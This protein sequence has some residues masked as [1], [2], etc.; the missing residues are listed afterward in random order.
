[1]ER[2]FT[3]Q[4]FNRPITLRDQLEKIHDDEEAFTPLTDNV[5]TALEITTEGV[6]HTI[7]TP[8]GQVFAE[9]DS[10]EAAQFIELAPRIQQLMFSHIR[11]LL[12]TAESCLDRI[13][14]LDQAIE[15]LAATHEKQA[16]I[17]PIMHGTYPCKCSCH[18]GP[19]CPDCKRQH[20]DFWLRS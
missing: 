5:E 4:E 20:G 8:R 1:M 19:P 17:R 16:L 15:F 6:R 9:T 14:T 7:A 10:L 13:A 11:F 18:P 3:E 2:H 12:K